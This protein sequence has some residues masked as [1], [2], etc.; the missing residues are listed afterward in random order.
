MSSWK[1]NKNQILSLKHGCTFI[2]EKKISSKSGRITPC[3]LGQQ[4]RRKSMPFRTAV[5]PSQKAITERI[6]SCK[7]SCNVF[8]KNK[9]GLNYFLQEW[10]SCVPRKQIGSKLFPLRETALYF[11]KTNQERIISFKSGCNVFIENNLGANCFL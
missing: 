8:L 9:L 1:T 5:I 6:I 2:H 4:T 10:L 11:M 3:L 7:S